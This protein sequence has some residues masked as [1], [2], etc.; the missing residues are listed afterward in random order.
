MPSHPH[1]LLDPDTFLWG[2]STSAFQI[3]GAPAADWTT[4]K[5]K[6]AEDGAV[7]VRG[8]DHRARQDA[9]LGLL[10]EIGANAYRYSIE[11]S[12]VVPARGEWDAAEVDR[13]VRVARSLRERGIE[14]VVTLHHFT[15]PAWLGQEGLDWT[16]EAFVSEFLR[17]ATRMVEALAGD[18]RIWVTLNEPNVHV[19]GGFLTGMT[20]PGKRGF[21]AAHLAL[22]NMLR[23]HARLY[24]VIH[25]DSP[26]PTAVGIA[27][28][29]LC[30]APGR[31]D[32]RLDRWAARMAD[33]IYNDTLIEAFRTGAVALRAIPVIGQVTVLP[34]RGHLDFLGVNYYTRALVS[35]SPFD[36]R[37]YRYFWEDHPGRGLIETSWEV[38]P[39][40]LSD[41]LQKAASLGLPLVITENGAAEADDDRKVAFL[42]EH[43]A[44]VARCRAEGMDVRGYF[45]WSLLDN[46]EWLR[47]LE[48]RFG[49]YH[50]DFNTLERTPT[51]AAT[52]YTRLV[53]AGIGRIGIDMNT[54]PPQPHSN[55]TPARS[56]AIR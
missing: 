38:Y 48:P 39:E 54:L 46:Y 19:G 29:M 24:E 18:V 36:L 34:L 42:R 16:H 52:A 51:R 21:R 49:L 56:G 37:R 26:G 27:H 12:R 40:G 8:V 10:G 53:E 43:V 17:F 11:W 6:D 4:W 33:R 30:F 35:F 31:P 20:P 2:A 23:A 7:R 41:V 9:D 55:R 28:N 32:S 15:S 44:Q 22:T 1:P 14:P 50:V 13:Q 5:V 47:G 45:W 3:E 25:T